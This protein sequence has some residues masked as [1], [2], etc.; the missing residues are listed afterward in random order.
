M[1]RPSIVRSVMLPSA[2]LCALLA[3]ACSSGGEKT[4]TNTATSN[5]PAAANQSNNNAN[6][7]QSTAGQTNAG[8]VT[9]GQTG[10]KAK[11]NLNTA[12]SAEF[13]A[14]IPGLGNRMVHEFEEYRPYKSMQQ[15]RREMGKYVKPE[16]IAEYEKYVYVPIA[17][18]DSDA[19]TLR[20]IPGL[21]EAEAD[22]LIAGRPYASRDAF[23][24]K[25]SEKVSA[26]ELAVAK[27]YLGG[28]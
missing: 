25:L 13:L 9:A 6:A 4:Q 21:D 1:L 22:A 15:F 12:S 20:Q 16:Q 5:A 11:L 24:T 14:Q 23:L 26:E 3:T 28:Q 7:G 19:A 2:L 10:G 8:Q 18:N 17:E 27:T